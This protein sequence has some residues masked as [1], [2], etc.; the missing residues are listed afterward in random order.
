MTNT[1]LLALPLL[2]AAQ[3]QKHVTM[4]EA[5]FL[6]DALT[7]IAVKEQNRS[8]PP[9]KPDPGDRYLIGAT[10]SGAFVGKAGMLAA[11]DGNG[12]NY[13]TPKAGFLIYV[14]SENRLYV[15]DGVALRNVR[16]VSA[17]ID[18]LFRLGIGTGTDLNNVLS[19]KGMSALFAALGSGEGGNGSFRFTLNKEKSASVLSQLYQT[20]WSGRAE[21]GLMGDDQYRIKVSPDGANWFESFVVDSASGAARF[22]SGIASLGGGAFAFRNLVINPEFSIAQRGPGPFSLTGAGPVNGFDRWRLTGATGVAATL[23]RTP[24]SLALAGT[25]QGNYFATWTVT[26]ATITSRACLETRLEQ[27][28]PLA[29]KKLALSFRYRATAPVSIALVQNFGVGG[30]PA[31]STNM[32]AALPLASAWRS[33]ALDVTLPSVSGKSASASPFL[34]L[35]FIASQAGVLD[36]ADIQLEE[37]FATPFERRPPAFELALC[38]RYFRRSASALNAA[39]LA[40]EMRTPPPM[41]G[42]GPFDYDAEFE[43]V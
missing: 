39:D 40:I 2:A 3:A 30:S 19:V 42:T 16:D 8:A 33:I 41:S 12:W 21:T 38:R 24:L 27:L 43:G 22:P 32:M 35:Q 34:A 18:S 29:G 13:T 36:L 17:A 28:I 20:G 15:H 23:T 25:M 10:P 7:Q 6:V 1:P 14:T 11:F 31:V 9:E 26:S 37:G 5:L 4:N